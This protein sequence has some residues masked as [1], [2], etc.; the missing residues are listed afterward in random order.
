MRVKPMLLVT[1]LVLMCLMA[2]VSIRT[3]HDRHAPAIGLA[4]ETTTPES[5]STLR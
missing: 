2:A 4:A 1:G 5:S 3:L